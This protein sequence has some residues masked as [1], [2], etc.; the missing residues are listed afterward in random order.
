M[1]IV[2]AGLPGTGTTTIARAPARRLRAMHVRIDTIE[3]ALRSCDV[4]KEDVGPAG[5]VVAYGVAEESSS[6]I[7]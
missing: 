6:P 2:F 4:L 1:L 5:Y 7:R 3:Q